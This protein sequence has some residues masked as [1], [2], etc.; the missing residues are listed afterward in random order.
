MHEIKTEVDLTKPTPCQREVL[1]ALARQLS[2]NEITRLLHIAEAIT[3]IDSE[4]LLRAY[5]TA[6]EAFLDRKVRP[7]KPRSSPNRVDPRRSI[8]RSSCT[9]SSRNKAKR[10]EAL[11]QKT[12]RRRPCAEPRPGLLQ[13]VYSVSMNWPVLASMPLLA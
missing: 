7:L 11:M 5:A 12:A 9:G 2:N 6:Q 3:N 13:N 10:L 8:A 4:A 1:T